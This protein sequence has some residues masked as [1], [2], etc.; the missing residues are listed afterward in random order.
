LVLLPGVSFGA[1]FSLV[2]YGS[3]IY[4]AFSNYGT[5]VGIVV[6]GFIFLISILTTILSLRAKTWRRLSLNQEID[7]TS[8]AQPSDELTI[9]QCGVAISRLSPAGKVEF[10]GKTYEARSVDV[11]IAQRENVEVVGFDNFTVVV[12]K[13]N[14]K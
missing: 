2:F 13:V 10:G 7:S 14:N 12:R 8:M 4:K 3:A 9:G 6:L 5:K 11:Y 1:V